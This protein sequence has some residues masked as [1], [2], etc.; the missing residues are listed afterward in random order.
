MEP[1]ILADLKQE[2]DALSREGFRVLAVAGRDFDPDRETYTKADEAGLTLLGY[3]AFLD[4]PKPGVRRAIESLQR[5]GIQIKV[6]TGDNE[7]VAGK[8]CG[9]VGIPAR[10]IVTGVE[11]DALS[12]GELAPVANRTHVFAR[13]S[14]VQK[15]RIVRSL[16][17]SGRVAGFLGDGI[18]DAPALKAADVGISV[19]NAAD[20]AKESA[21]IILLRKSLAVLEEGVLEGRKTFGNIVKYIRMV[22]SSNFGN[23]FSMTGASFLFPFLPM[24]PIQVLINNLLYDFSQVAIP[25]DEVDED[26]LTR[27]RAW[28]LASIRR[29]ILVFGPLSSVFDYLTFGV[30]FWG[31]RAQPAQFQTAWFVESLMTQTLV[32]HVIRTARS[33]FWASGSSRF[34]LVSSIAIVLFGLGLSMSSAGHALKF[35]VLPEPLY[36]AI[37]AVVALYLV[38]AEFLKRWFVR[39]YGYE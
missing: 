35:T 31:F 39:K 13:L 24:L 14:P 10:E 36:Y 25:T 20:I 34:L 33:P 9:D 1:L 4:P 22:A 29:Y 38:A 2:H 17:G 18:N 32:I 3:V 8:I 5:L 15:E 7:L 12:D 27:P 26:Y 30:L 21:D 28:N 6:L 16:R 37:F 11:V 23:M 19:N